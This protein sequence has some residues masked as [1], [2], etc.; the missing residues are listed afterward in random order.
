[1]D[2]TKDFSTQHIFN[3]WY[4]NLKNYNQ[5]QNLRKEHELG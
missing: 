5:D 3:S 4:Q 2:A 1:M